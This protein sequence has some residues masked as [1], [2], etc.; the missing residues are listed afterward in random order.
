MRKEI[1]YTTSLKYNPLEKK[2]S[3]DSPKPFFFQ[4]PIIC[5]LKKPSYL[6]K[7]KDLF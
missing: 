7:S 2:N 4:I 6:N 5:F 1:Y 3:N